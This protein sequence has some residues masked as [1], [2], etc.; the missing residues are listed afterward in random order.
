MVAC[1]IIHDQLTGSGAPI[2]VLVKGGDTLKVEWELEGMRHE[3]V[4][5]TGPAEFVFDGEINV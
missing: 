1:A 5:L 3:N 4:T 2:N